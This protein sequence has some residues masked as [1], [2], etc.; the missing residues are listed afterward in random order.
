MQQIC[1]QLSSDAALLKYCKEDTTHININIAWYR[2]ENNSLITLFKNKQ[3]QTWFGF[4]LFV[5]VVRL[6]VYLFVA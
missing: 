3:K 4:R 6:F 2:T 1:S 5:Y